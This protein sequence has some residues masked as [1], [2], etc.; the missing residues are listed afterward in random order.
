MRL[1]NFFLEQRLHELDHSKEEVGKVVNVTDPE[2]IHQWL[3][4]FRFT[5]GDRVILLDDS[6]FEFISEFKDL[7]PGGATLEIV[8]ARENSRK[9]FQELFLFQSL[10]KGDHL[11]W[12]LEKGTELGVSR[13]MPILADRSEKKNINF[14]RAKKIIVEASEQ[15]GRGKLPRFYEI[16]KLDEAFGQYDAK[17]LVF[18]PGG[19]RFN[20]HE[21]IK[22]KN[23][24]AFIGPEGGWSDRE[25]E[26]FKQKGVPIYSFSDLT[27]RSE[28]AAIAIASLVLL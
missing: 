6:G 19:E 23:L 14:E 9:P 5:L 10:I 24:A 17:A 26:L 3:R 2:K 27:L 4:V 25:I 22:E 15:C 12:V 18:H 11:E 16:M 28:T 7:G 20:K 8:E 1:H 21:F 13:F